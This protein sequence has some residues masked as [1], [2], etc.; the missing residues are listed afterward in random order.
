MCQPQLYYSTTYSE[1]QIQAQLPLREQGA[2][3]VLLSHNNATMTFWV[4]LYIMCGIL[5]NLYGN[6][7]IHASLQEYNTHMF[8]ISFLK[9][10]R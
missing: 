4:L 8:D 9:N 3:F 10:P 6:K 1:L 7:C 5:A 2:S